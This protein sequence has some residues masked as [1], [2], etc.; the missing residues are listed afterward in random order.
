MK[1]T[2]L[3]EKVGKKFRAST[4]QPIPMET[5]GKSR[6]EAVQHLLELA[7]RRINGGDL[8]QITIPGLPESNPWHAFAGIWRD[9]PDF[10]AFLKNI[11]EY[12]YTVNRPSAAT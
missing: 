2:V 4:S 3:I 9:H 7:E 11:A 10:D 5:E 6:D 12:R 1:A 8:L